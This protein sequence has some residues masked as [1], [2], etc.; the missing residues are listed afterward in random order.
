M[1]ITTSALLLCVLGAPSSL[2][3]QTDH[4]GFTSIFDGKSLKGW[5]VSTQTGHSSTSKHH[6][7]GKWV[8]EDGALIGVDEI[9]VGF[10]VF[11]CFCSIYCSIMAT[12]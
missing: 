10:E 3:A 6:T 4:E 5:H 7:G 12:I 8:V 11:R 1:R 9:K 2:R